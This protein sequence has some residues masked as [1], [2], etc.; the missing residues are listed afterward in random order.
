MPRNSIDVSQF[1]IVPNPWGINRRGA[2][3][4]DRYIG[5]GDMSKAAAALGYKYSTAAT[6]LERALKKIP[7]S[8]RLHKLI[9]WRDFRGLLPPSSRP[10]PS[11]A[12]P[13]GTTN[14]Q[15]RSIDLFAS[16]L[17]FTQ[18]ADKIG[19]S[20][21]SEYDHLRAGLLKVPGDTT[22]QRLA[23]WRQFREDQKRDPS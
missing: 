23:A 2:A 19:K 1:P 4:L 20:T 3:L 13:F 9:Y 22:A 7:G 17:S 18:V 16:G 15:A 12:N 21:R 8:C 14:F 11:S 5:I 10:P 6:G